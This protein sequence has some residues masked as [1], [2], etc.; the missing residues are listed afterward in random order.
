M[1]D[2]R[3][4]DR[5]QKG[6]RVILDYENEKCVMVIDGGL[7]TGVIANTAG[8]LGV[9][10]GKRQPET[11]GPDV[12]DKGGRLHLGIVALPVPILRS[13]A[14]QLK[15]LRERLYQP[16]FAGVTVVDFSDVAQGCR[17]YEEYIER[18]AAVESGEMTYLG[19]AL[20]GPK[21]LVNRLTGS[22]P[23]LR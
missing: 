13:D 3:F 18:A 10:L 9:T 11:V 2:C 20:C 17:V 14:E 15:A 8:I 6:A 23:L 5:L 19:L 7:P 21:K 1:T 22:M 4:K 16:E 12:T